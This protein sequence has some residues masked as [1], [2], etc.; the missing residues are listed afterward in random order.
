MSHPSYH[1]ALPQGVE[2]LRWPHKHPLPESEVVAFFQSRDLSPSRWSNGP[3]AVYAVHVHEYLKTLFCVNGRI[4][5]SL[6]DLDRTV[7][8]RPGDRLSLPR[9]IRHGATVG[10]EGVT[11]IEAGE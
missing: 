8:L 9:G 1:E 6:P 5:F 4:T 3:G 2:V 7:E 11:C 10:P